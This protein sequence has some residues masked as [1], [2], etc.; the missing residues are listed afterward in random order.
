MTKEEESGDSVMQV[1]V[2]LDWRVNEGEKGFHGRRL[3]T[4]LNSY[5][6]VSL[7]NDHKPETFFGKTKGSIGCQNSKNPPS[8]ADI[9]VSYMSLNWMGM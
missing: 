4:F 3:H 1:G 7:L 8:S 6:S 9:T 2:D 5:I